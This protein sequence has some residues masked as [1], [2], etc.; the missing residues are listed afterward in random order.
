MGFE[1]IE[2]LISDGK[3]KIETIHFKMY[4]KWCTKVRLCSPHRYLREK[5][6]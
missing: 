1:A 3:L 4:K 5:K 6:C 2:F